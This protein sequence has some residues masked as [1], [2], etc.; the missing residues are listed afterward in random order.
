MNKPLKL[1]I[2]ICSLHKRGAQLDELLLRLHNQHRLDEVEILIAID[3]GQTLVGIKRNR[4]VQRAVGEYIVH[5]DDDDLVHR[6]YVSKILHA[7]DN[8]PDVDAIVLRGERIENGLV[9]SNVLFDYRVKMGPTQTIDG[10]IWRTPGHLCPIHHRIAKAVPFPE[11]EP[12]DL[13]WCDEIAPYLMTEA[14]AGQPG[15]VLYYYRWDSTKLNRWEQF[16][17]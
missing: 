2:C 6:A 14:R 12:E 11:V 9:G 10:V 13:V 7:I 5:I 3:A 15:D 8:N 4:L 1:S 16:S 17:G